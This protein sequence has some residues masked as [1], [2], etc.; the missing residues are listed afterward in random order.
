MIVSLI[1]R[2]AEGIDALIDNGTVSS[3]KRIVLYGLGRY[4]FAMRTI[5]S[6]RDIAVDA[7]LTDDEAEAIGVRR[8]IKDYASRFFRSERDVIDVLSIKDKIKVDGKDTVILVASADYKSICGKLS[9][10]GLM[11]YKDFYKV[12]DC[13]E[14]DIDGFLKNKKRMS[15]EEI[16]LT[17]KQMLKVIDEYCSAKDLRVWASGGTMLG[18]VRHKGF[19]PWDDDIDVFLPIEDYMKLVHDFP[20]DD[21]YFFSGFGMPDGS[22]FMESYARMQDRKTWLDHDMLIVR[23]LEHVWLDVF[24]L[25]GLPSDEDERRKFFAEFREIN[26]SIVQDFYKNDGSMD[27]FVRRFHDMDEYLF[28]YPFDEAE[29]VGVLGTRYWEKDCTPRSVYDQTIRM[30]FEDMEIGVPQGYDTYLTN[31]YGSDWHEIPNESRRAPLH[32]IRGYWA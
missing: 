14:P 16:K 28:R 31:L 2:I 10:I 15:L 25:V 27:V 13:Y 17:S 1:Q 7:Y 4:S 11:E 20:E 21:R 12:Y 6:H 18:A 22:E 30:R 26:K 9:E 3:K 5:L 23:R 24:P 29:Y 8:E 32:R 19:I